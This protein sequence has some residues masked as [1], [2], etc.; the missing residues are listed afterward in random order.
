[1][2][3]PL[4]ASMPQFAQL[5]Y[6]TTVV[7]EALDPV[8]GAAVS[9]VTASG[10]ELWADVTLGTTDT[11]GSTFTPGPYMLVAGPDA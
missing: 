7:L 10:V 6:N 3:A 4:T 2:A 1:M 5:G 11:G 9:G 8:T